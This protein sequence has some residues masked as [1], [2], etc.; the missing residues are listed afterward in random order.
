V[1]RVPQEAEEVP[2]REDRDKVFGADY[3]L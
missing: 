1:F 3:A 2:V